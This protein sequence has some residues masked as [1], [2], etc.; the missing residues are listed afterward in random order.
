MGFSSV[1]ALVSDPVFLRAKGSS[2]CA[3]GRGQTGCTSEREIGQL[4]RVRLAPT[5]WTSG[6]GCDVEPLVQRSLCTASA[7]DDDGRRANG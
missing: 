4:K 2:H 3:G 1:P 5:G 7:A 6:L